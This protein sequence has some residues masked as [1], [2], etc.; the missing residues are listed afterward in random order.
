MLFL[1]KAVMN[2]IPM[3]RKGFELL[4]DELQ[5]LEQFDR[6]SV[7]KD[8]ELARE[9]GDL[10]ENAEYKAAKEKQR[11]IENRINYLRNRVS[12][13][14]IID[15][16]KFIGKK[17]I[18]FG[19]KVSLCGEDG[20]EIEYQIVGEDE[21]DINVSKISILSPIAKSL[22]GKKES[23]YCEFNSKKYRINSV[24]YQ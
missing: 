10:S 12:L 11:F 7:I 8:I 16:T 5:K 13:A 22:I 3:T 15:T 21:S 23:E 19:A 20:E 9:F 24:S 14:E 1:D 18:V 17:N 2:R 4:Q 6:I